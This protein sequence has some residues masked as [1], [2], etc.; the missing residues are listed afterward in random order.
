ME[1]I[2]LR[3]RPEYLEESIA[4]LQKTWS[5]ESTK[6]VYDDCLRHSLGADGPVPQWYLLKDGGETAGCAG[7]IANDFNSRQ[8]LYPWLAALFIEE[9]YRGN[10]FG[11]ILIDAAKR[12]AKN[13]G[14]KKLYLCTDLTTYYEKFGFEHIGECFDLFGGK[15][16]IYEMA[17]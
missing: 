10:N 6:M 15:P 11:E 9:K 17:L 3:Q 12:D 13:A 4:Y 2:S 5:D 14:F 1:I 7:L 16:C 8:D